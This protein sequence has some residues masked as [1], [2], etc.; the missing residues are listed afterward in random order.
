LG[1]VP[2]ELGIVYKDDDV[3]RSIYSQ[4]PF[5]LNAPKSK[6]SDCVHRLTKAIIED[7]IGP[8]DEDKRLSGYLKRFFAS[9][10]KEG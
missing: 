7:T 1:V 10:D 4:K 5:L 8:S 3:E 9:N 6:A 2:K